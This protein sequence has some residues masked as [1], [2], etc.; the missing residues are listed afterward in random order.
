MI[1]IRDRNPTHTTPYLTIAIIAINVL[2]FLS[3]P[4]FG[5]R[6]EQRRFFLCSAAIPWEV[7]HGQQVTE[8]GRAFGCSGKNVWLSVIYSM[9]LHGGWLHIAGN[10]LYLWVFGNNIEDRLGRSKF[11]LFYVGAGV[12][13]TLAQSFV[14]GGT[15][16]PTV[17]SL[18]PMVGASGAVA[19]ILGAYILLFPRA[20]VETLVIFFFITWVEIPAVVLLGFW[21]M[22]QVLSGLAS[23]GA[24]ASSGV[25]FFAHIGGF[26]AGMALLAILR[27]RAAPP[28][29]HEIEEIQPW[30]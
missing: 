1:P 11:I 17:A 16:E 2:V 29:P 12:V 9:F 22:L 8:I 21:F 6:L 14:A 26:L 24:T 20:R 3:E 19:G 15:G 30:A 27:P 28:P 23:V 10:M 18:T 4:L 13:A 5:S 25:A 7:L